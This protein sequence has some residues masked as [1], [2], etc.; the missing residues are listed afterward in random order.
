MLHMPTWQAAIRRVPMHYSS[1]LV[2]EQRRPSASM[3]T[4]R[5]WTMQ[6]APSWSR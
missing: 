2:N 5:L 3:R 6:P 1:A 4:V